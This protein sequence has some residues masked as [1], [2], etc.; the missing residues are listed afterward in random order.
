M[1]DRKNTPPP[2]RWVIE[3]WIRPEHSISRRGYWE[4]LSEDGNGPTRFTSQA[5]A[6]HLFQ[7]KA[8]PNWPAGEVRIVKETRTVIL[9]NGATLPATEEQ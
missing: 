2:D 4:V 9:T 1:D 5:E 3:G 7:H 8:A 6:R